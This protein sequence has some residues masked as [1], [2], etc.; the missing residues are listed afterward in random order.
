LEAF[1]DSSSDGVG[2][3]VVLICG[4]GLRLAVANGF[5]RNRFFSFHISPEDRCRSILKNVECAL[6]ESVHNFSHDLD[7]IL[8]I[9]SVKAETGDYKTSV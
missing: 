2:K 5:Y 1:S 4:L 6:V 7:F 9:E 3:K 8:S